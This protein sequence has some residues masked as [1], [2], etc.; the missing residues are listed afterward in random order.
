MRRDDSREDKLH[1]RYSAYNPRGEK[2]KLA[3]NRKVDKAEDKT[4]MK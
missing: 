1:K 4:K 3:M 2:V